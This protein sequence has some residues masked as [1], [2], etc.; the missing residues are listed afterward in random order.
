MSNNKPKLPSS[1]GAEKAAKAVSKFKNQQPSDQ[2][3]K[4]ISE[5]GVDADTEKEK[6]PKPVI[7]AKDVEL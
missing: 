3:V 6:L 7:A 2:L 5:Y 1:G 4:I